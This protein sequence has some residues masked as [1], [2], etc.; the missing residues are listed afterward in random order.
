[1]HCIPII[2]L[3]EYNES[4]FD[5]RYLVRMTDRFWEIKDNY[6]LLKVKV[7]TKASKNSIVGVRNNELL[8]CVTAVPE[9]GKANDAIVK[10]LSKKFRCAKTKINL[11][12]GGKSKNKLFRIDEVID[13]DALIEN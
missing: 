11:V 10:L 1:M 4:V 7:T 6:S 2:R 9:N 3:N 12:S 8:I 13:F 5:I